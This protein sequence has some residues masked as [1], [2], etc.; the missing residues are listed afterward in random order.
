MSESDDIPMSDS[1][2]EPEQRERVPGQPEQREHER[3]AAQLAPSVG[4]NVDICGKL[5][6][7]F[8]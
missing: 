3:G 5:G 8:V 2:E 1:D 6:G 7:I 4:S